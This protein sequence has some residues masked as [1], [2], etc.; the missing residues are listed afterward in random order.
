MHEKRNHKANDVENDRSEQSAARP[1][2][3]RKQYEEEIAKLHAELVKLQV[4]GEAD[5]STGRSGL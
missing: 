1:K 3:K 2:L 4:L 5:R